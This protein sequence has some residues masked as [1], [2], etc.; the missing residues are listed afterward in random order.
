MKKHPKFRLE[1]EELT[2]GAQEAA[3]SETKVL[4]VAN[5][6]IYFYSEIERGSI[7]TLNKNLRDLAN[8]NISDTQ[9]RELEC[10]VPIKLHINSYGGNV[11]AGLAGMDEILK[12]GEKVPVHTIIDGCC[13]SAATFLSVVGSKRYIH[14]HAFMLIHQLSGAAWGKYYEMKDDMTNADKLMELIKMIYLERTNIPA[15]KIDEILQHDLWFD[16]KTCLK[17]GLVDEII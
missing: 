12:I 7:L 11:F 13:A 14:R 10:T 5:N 17:Y 16:S 1:V 8:T 9:I 2:A 4:E 15:E 6:R 3:E